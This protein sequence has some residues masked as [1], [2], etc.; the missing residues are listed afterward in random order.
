MRK[1]QAHSTQA[2]AS[3]RPQKMA[4]SSAILAVLVTAA[5]LLSPAMSLPVFTGDAS[6]DFHAAACTQ[7]DGI[8]WS[9]VEA[10]LRQEVA[11]AAAEAGGREPR[12][13]RSQGHA[14]PSSAERDGG[15][16]GARERPPPRRSFF[17]SA[18]HRHRGASCRRPPH[19]TGATLPRRA[20]TSLSRQPR[21]NRK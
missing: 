21:P 17:S 15:R 9:S 6:P 13:G 2:R 14:L 1:P 5:A 3:L 19:D 8:V 11:V 4:S 7:L 20:Q 18:A 12:R 10:A 16:M